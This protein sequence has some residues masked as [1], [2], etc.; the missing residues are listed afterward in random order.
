MN[1]STSTL[2]TNET[3][4]TQHAMVIVWG[5]FARTIGLLGR[6]AQVP[7]VQKT[8]LRAPHE[9]LVEFFLGLLTGMEYLTDL[10][11]GAA[12]LVKDA[13]VAA[14]WQLHRMADASGVSRTLWACDEQTVQELERQL[15]AVGQPFLDRA[16]SDLR[17]RHETL[18][19]DA[20]LTG[21]G[22][23][24]TSQT[25]PGA[26]FGYMD[27]EV[28]L[29]YQ[30]AEICLQTDLFGRQWLSAQHHPGDTISA[31]CLL[32]LLQAAERRLG[33]HPHRRTELVQARI[34]AC[35][36]AQATL[37][38]APEAN[39]RMTS[40]TTRVA[41]L[42]E[43]I[44]QAEARLQTLGS[45]PESPR[46]AGPYS[47]LNR[48]TKQQAGWQGQLRRAQAQLAQAT[49]VAERQQ[50]RLDK[51]VQTHQAERQ[52]LQA[53]Y[54]RLCAEND[55]QPNAPHCKIRLDAG[56][57]TGANLTELIELGYDIDTKSAN[58]AVVQA[59][60][61][62]VAAEVPWT[63]VG[64][65][66]E[67][68]SWPD[69]QIHDCP[70]PLLVGLE[71]FHTPQ[72][73]LHAVLIR[74]QDGSPA[75]DLNLTQWFHDYNG[76][77]TIEAG[78]KEEKTTFKVQ[79]LMNRS[80]AGIRIQAALTVFAANFVRWADEWIRPRIEQSTRRF[81][82]VLSSPKR[83]V[84]IAANSPATVEHTAGRTRVRFS[85]L[86]SFDGVV[87]VLSDTVGW[88]LPLFAND[89]FSSA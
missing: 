24:S 57:S 15:A 66:A 64:R 72:S 25:F 3:N 84:R 65:N 40:L 69:Y 2:T 1:Q 43:Q 73:T 9:K 85:H 14:A 7:I 86:S 44:Q 19:L 50:Q 17:Q 78:N 74:Y 34:A 13:E 67:M 87:I 21:R 35:E 36:E 68:L 18:V 37:A 4:P 22:V 59:L 33:C 79:H 46:Q 52:R 42:T 70:Y 81:D 56:F 6:L 71:R 55:R 29:G 53:R 31:P 41:H 38:Q 8:V 10:S 60:C 16:V 61:N 20:D 51:K 30:L 11:E 58:P 27:G 62:R 77:Q 26:A 63:T 82:G 54:A 80:A 5:H 32:D 39:G 76:R 28:R 75:S 49:A 48:L 47:Q 23:S 88:Q 89:H 83:L 45:Q 12:P